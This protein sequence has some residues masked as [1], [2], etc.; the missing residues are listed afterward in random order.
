VIENVGVN[1]TRTGILEAL[2]MM[3][4]DIQQENQREVAGEP[5][6]DLRVRSSRL[7]SCT[8]AGD[9]IPRLIDEVPILAVA[10]VF[11]EGTTLIRDAAELRV[12]ESDRI[13]VMAQQLNQMGAKVT[14]LPDGMEITGGSSLVG[15]DVDSYTDHRIAMSLAIASLNA[16]GKTNI[17]R[18]EAAAVSYPTFV[19]T[20]QEVCGN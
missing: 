1:P 7:K 13:A 18:A 10:A 16:S 5:V 12:K 8:I 2:E 17:H 9:I 6:A 4:A 15:T 20:L 11:A 14:E 19:T 3:G